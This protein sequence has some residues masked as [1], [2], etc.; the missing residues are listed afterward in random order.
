MTQ[1]TLQAAAYLA[2]HCYKSQASLCHGIQG[3]AYKNG[4]ES[5]SHL[6]SLQQSQQLTGADQH[7][8]LNFHRL[9]LVSCPTFLAMLLKRNSGRVACPCQLLLTR[10]RLGSLAGQ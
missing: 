10:L 7:A 5:Q 3:L 6:V 4:Q 9:M 2:S 1:M 8:H